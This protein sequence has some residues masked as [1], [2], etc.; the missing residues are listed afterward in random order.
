MVNAGWRVRN[1]NIWYK[2]NGMPHCL[3]PDTKVFIKNSSTVK[4]ITL[5]SLSVGDNILTPTGW[6][7][8][9]NKWKTKKKPLEL[10]IGKVD[11]II[12]SEDHRFAISHDKRR[13][14]THYIEAGSVRGKE[15]KGHYND[16]FVY[17][18]MQSFLYKGKV[19]LIDMAKDKT[20]DWFA[21]VR[22]DTKF[23]ETFTPME[24][25]KNSNDPSLKN[26]NSDSKNEYY[27]GVIRVHRI[28]DYPFTRIK[29]KDSTISENR[30]YPLK[31][32]LGW[33]LGLYTAEG[34]FNATR[35]FQ[36]KITLH[37]DE[38]SIA[39]EFILTFAKY[40]GHSIQKEIVKD[41][42]RD[43]LFTSACFYT[44]AKKILIKGKV[45]TKKL[46]IDKFLNTP[47]EF[48]EG[49]IRGYFDGDGSKRGDG[50]IVTSVSKQLIDDVQVLLA[51]VGELYS[52]GMDKSKEKTWSDSYRLWSNS[53]HKFDEK[54]QAYVRKV[55]T[56]LGSTE[57]DMIDIEVDGG[58][59]LIE[60]GLISHNSVKDRM[61]VKTEDFDFFVK[62]TEYF[63]DLDSVRTP[64][65]PATIERE[66]Y[67]RIP[68]SGKY[69]DDPDNPNIQAYLGD[70]RSLEKGA[71]PGNVF[72]AT[73]E[74]LNFFVKEPRYFFDLDAIRVKSKTYE[75]DPR[76]QT[77]E[78][79]TYDGKLSGKDDSK[80]TK[81]QKTDRHLKSKEFKNPGN[82]LVNTIKVPK[83]PTIPDEQLVGL[84]VEKI[85]TM[86]GLHPKG[87]CP[88]C[89]GSW[90]KHV[91]RP[92]REK[93]LETEGETSMR[94]FTPCD[95]KGKN[96]ANVTF[97]DYWKQPQSTIRDPTKSGRMGNLSA[98]EQKK[99]IT[100][101]N[102]Y[103][104]R[105][106]ESKQFK[107]TEKK[108]ALVAL[109]EVTSMMFKR[110]IA[111]YEMIL[112]DQKV[113]SRL[114][115][116]RAEIKKK[117]FTIIHKHALVSPDNVLNPFKT[118]KM[119]YN[120]P[121]VHGLVN[122]IEVCLDELNIALTKGIDPGTLWAI[123]TEP[124]PMAHFAVY[125]TKLITNPIKA[126]CPKYVCARCGKPKEW[127][128]ECDSGF[129]KG[130]VLDPFFGSG[131]TGIVAKRL[132]RDFIGIE[133]NKDYVKIAIKRMKMDKKSRSTGL[134][135][136]M[137]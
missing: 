110:E 87:S 63:Y 5:S 34:G 13:L 121:F 113:E 111:D 33:L 122:T 43:I 78:E 10:E 56:D 59:F 47:T 17:Q 24:L 18:N 94:I 54:G 12:C 20:L 97:K 129:N 123:N 126:G 107:G 9:L 73:H 16:R 46:D 76:C 71:N 55:N 26:W 29:A 68:Q 42:Y 88:V 58:I 101:R 100:K 98:K 74:I 96:P 31:Y 4:Q 135:N 77:D 32:N 25:A 120:H 103:Q 118:I 6:K 69:H 65:K 35:G 64:L 119:T 80:A 41:N 114:K 85:I 90:S 36:G 124:M 86:H 92:K 14:A 105:I 19:A 11:K 72:T 130:I 27:N 89:G 117:G 115:E 102:N 106:V 40:F 70:K 8:V 109:D 21:D 127:N 38:T 137:E 39:K 62:N 99:V 81:H 52:K 30:Y 44:L 79:I 23:K 125:P 2:P 112:R 83:I 50:Q 3:H 84:S 133:L 67:T 53:Y 131:T 134:G 49:F 75:Q 22:G 45:K 57:I 60:H 51:S 15:A 37:K 132:G 91:S 28:P 116:R 66:K 93:R 95:P 108:E 61:T 136:L 7:K 104:K 48:R 1:K 82:V 128:C